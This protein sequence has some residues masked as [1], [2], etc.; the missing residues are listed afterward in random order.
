[1]HVPQL[2]A[3][4]DAFR[5]V[6]NKC[7]PQEGTPSQLQQRVWVVGDSRVNVCVLPAQHQCYTTNTLARFS[8]TRV[9]R[10]VF[11][12]LAQLRG[13]QTDPH[14]CLPRAPECCY[15]VVGDSLLPQLFHARH[16]HRNGS[17]HTVCMLHAERC[18]YAIRDLGPWLLGHVINVGHFFQGLQR[19][20]Y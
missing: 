1:M 2:Q 13:T 7:V 6:G 16:L 4:Q 20:D 14:S 3:T 8:Q 11:G 10:V 9:L 17:P 12:T 15:D 18:T 5:G 19:D